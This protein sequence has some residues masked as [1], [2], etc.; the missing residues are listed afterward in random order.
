MSAPAA[1]LSALDM[2]VNLVHSIEGL[3]RYVEEGGPDAEIMAHVH[4]LGPRQHA[5]G[6]LAGNLALVSIAQDIH[7]IRLVLARPGQ[8]L[9]AQEPDQDPLP[10]GGAV[11]D[12][13]ATREHMKRWASG[14]TDHPGEEAPG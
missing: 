4:G 13:R 3:S 12:A 11:D 1:E 9:T 7:A 8:V 2:A 6:Q 5:A 10:F 14:E